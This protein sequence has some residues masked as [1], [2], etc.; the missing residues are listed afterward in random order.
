MKNRIVAFLLALSVAFCFAACAD[1]GINN[2][3]DDDYKQQSYIIAREKGFDGTLEE[4]IELLKGE[5]G[6]DGKSA[7]MLAVENAGFE[8]TLAEWLDSLKGK[9]GLDG[10]DGKDGSDGRGI[11]DI[12]IADGNL[13]VKYTDGTD[14]IDLGTVKGADGQDG[15]DG[16]KGDDGFNGQPGT[17]GKDG[18]DGRSI[19]DMYVAN[20]CLYVLYSDALSSVNIGSVKGEKGD[21][22]KT[23]VGVA[24]AKVE[25]GALY[26]RYTDSE[27]FVRVGTVKGEKGDK[28]DTGAPG[29]D[30][31]DGKD[32]RGV[33][34]IKIDNGALYIK[35]TDSS[36]YE[37]LGPVKG[38]QGESGKDGQDGKNLDIND[39]YAAAVAGGYNGTF[40]E[41][42]RAYLKVEINASPEQTV[43]K[44]LLSTVA[45]ASK[46]SP[47]A[48]SGGSGVIY[49]GDKT[50]GDVYI[51]TNFHVIFNSKYTP[52]VCSD[53][54]VSFYGMDYSMLSRE[55][56]N[57]TEE[58]I[59][60][61]VTLEKA[62]IKAEFVAGS[63]TY[64]I[65]VLKIAACQRY[66]DGPYCPAEM[67]EDSDLIKEG[68]TSYVVGN[69]EG[70]G[71]SAASGIISLTNYELKVSIDDAIGSMSYRVMRTDAAVNHGNSGGGL[72]NKDG[73]LMGIVNAKTQSVTVDNM[74]FA[75]P[76][77]VV[78]GVVS[79]LMRRENNPP[80]G[81][82]DVEKNGYGLYKCLLGVTVKAAY[83]YAYYDAATGL[84]TDKS[85][86]EV[87]ETSEGGAAYGLL[88][89]GD[90]VLS[91][92]VCGIKREIFRKYQ[93]GDL[94][95]FAAKG[96][97][98]TVT[99]ERGGRIIPVQIALNN[100]TY[101][102]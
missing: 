72:Y 39:I 3:T 83:S 41:F 79:N 26:I 65:A 67:I 58:E 2:K 21:T 54:Y 45:I 63:G 20:G 68:E 100:R 38:E 74:G 32:G 52:A 46:F 102:K 40:L 89:S 87:V 8:G 13:L 18:K 10:T 85:V 95:L 36:A 19:A 15:A 51:I 66:I 17:P 6:A 16:K 82:D 23:G 56:P 35:Y 60:Q 92:E 76:V 7:Y 25:N 22:G 93:L 14:Y 59:D 62:G 81:V 64:D 98:V 88:K 31:V 11:A 101:S 37:Y 30:G 70:H 91:M 80:P 12:K 4:W 69:A 55:N 50:T 99:V 9:A 97:V 77:N 73:K 48:V 53:I 5:P 44:T 84:V 24:E 71:L 75:I 78:K 28:G 1:N 34:S 27:T 43:S 47:T 94:L 49:K 96:D 86:I 57:Y 90:T 33:E 61:Y 29:Q 42:L